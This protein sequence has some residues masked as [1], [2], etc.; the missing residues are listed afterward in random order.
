[1]QRPWLGLALAVLLLVA[2]VPGAGVA[3]ATTSME[4][5]FVRLLNAE[6]TQRGLR[7]LTV[8]PDLQHVARDH[9]DTM[10]ARNLLHHNPTLATEV[11]GWSRITENVGRGP[12]AA[13]LHDALMASTGHRANILDSRV[14]QVG[15]GVTVVSGTVWVTQVFRA[16]TQPY[17]P[18]TGNGGFSDVPWSSVHRRDIEWLR[19]TGI[20]AGCGTDRFCPTAPV[21]REQ[22][23]SFLVRA[24]DLPPSSR[25][26]FR[27]VAGAHASDIRALAAAGVTR[28]CNPPI[29]DRFCPSSA[30]TREQ[31]ATF[32]TRI[33]NLPSVRGNRF[34]DV[35]GTHAANINALAASGIT[36][37]CNPPTNAR[38]CPSEVVSREQMAS[39]LARALR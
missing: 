9:S 7:Q 18:V 24:F 17:T 1:M 33:M 23:A 10:A 39:F 35:T 21:T 14:D 27:D 29:N 15:V 16:A 37:G 38:F 11:S 32:L 8:H 22:M 12:S 4:T 2:V 36:R 30:V 34:R 6:R 13:R 26:G 3:E 20:T 25:Y 28:G 5:D 31:M 19:D